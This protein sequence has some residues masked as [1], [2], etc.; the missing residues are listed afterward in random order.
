MID[1]F[2]RTVAEDPDSPGELLIELGEEICQMLD[3]HPGDSI[4]WL[5]NKD[6]S[7]TLKKTTSTP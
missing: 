2:V 4:E 5:D 6:G 3:W 1:T 7:W